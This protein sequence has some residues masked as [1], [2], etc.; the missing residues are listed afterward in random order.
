MRVHINNELVVECSHLLP[1][2]WNGWVQPVFT[3]RQA[4]EVVDR[5]VALGWATEDDAPFL[6]THIGNDEYVTYGFIWEVVGE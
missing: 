6:P 5:L 3:L 1:D 4:D 2:R